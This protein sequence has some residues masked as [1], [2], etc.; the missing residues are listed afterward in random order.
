MTIF[1]PSAVRRLEVDTESPPFVRSLVDTYQRMLTPR[2]ERLV[3]AALAS[4]PA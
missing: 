4:A 3:D 1:D 2:V